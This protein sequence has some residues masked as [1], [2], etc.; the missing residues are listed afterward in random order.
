V[1]R[2]AI[3]ELVDDGRTGILLDD[4][5]PEVLSH[6]MRWTLDRPKDYRQMRVAVWKKMRSQYSR[7]RFADRFLAAVSHLVRS[8]AA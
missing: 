5:N 8:K 7:Q 4:S 1:R 6:A 3:P 2:F